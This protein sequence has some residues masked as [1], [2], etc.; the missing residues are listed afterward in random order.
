MNNR[1]F[2]NPVIGDRVTFL[3]TCAETSGAC[4]EVEVLL[5]PGGGNS[6]HYHTTF[7]ET[8]EPLEGE[9]T[10]NVNGRRQVLKPGESAT[11]GP[12]LSH[13]FSNK[14][15]RAIR[16]RVVLTPGHSGFEE[17]IRIA[18]G[19]ARDGHTNKKGVPKKLSHLAL[20]INRSDTNMYGIF[21]IMVPLLKRICRKAMAK[22]VLDDL[23]AKYCN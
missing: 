11:V 23:Q 20:L 15:N 13:C 17:G 7:S 9:L 18:Y 4:T 2:E 16:F 21:S 22:G 5:M 8:F 19:L 3:R 10:V 14:S 12:M 1:T 6:D